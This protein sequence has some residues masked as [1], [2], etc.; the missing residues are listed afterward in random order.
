MP[1]W[2]ARS[3]PALPA[4]RRACVLGEE[5]HPQRRA[6]G[7][8]H[9]LEA[10]GRPAGAAVLV[11]AW[12]RCSAISPTTVSSWPSSSSLDLGQLAGLDVAPREVAQQVADG[13]QAEPVDDRLRASCAAS[14][15]PGRGSTGES[16][17]IT[18]A[19][20]VGSLDAT[21]GAGSA[22][23]HRRTP[24]RRQWGCVLLDARRRTRSASVAASSAPATSVTSSPPPP[25]SRSSDVAARRRTRSSPT[26]AKSPADRRRARRRARTGRPSSSPAGRR[27]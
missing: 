26:T 13:A 8:Q 11:G 6:V 24:R 19:A 1:R 14:A 16:R 5:R 3:R 25:S 27:P 21:R 23:G 18:R 22:P 17:V 4:R 12:P 7:A 10:V 15:A 2:P 20:S 9:R